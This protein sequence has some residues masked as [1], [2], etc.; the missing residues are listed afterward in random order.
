MW[1]KALRDESHRLA[2]PEAGLPGIAGLPSRREAVVA[3]ET[4]DHEVDEWNAWLAE[5]GSRDRRAGR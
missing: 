4:D 3:R 1:G 2:D 5:L